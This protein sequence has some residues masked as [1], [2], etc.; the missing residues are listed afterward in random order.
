MIVV[1]DFFFVNN[2]MV[3]EVPKGHNPSMLR[4]SV[5]V[6]EILDMGVS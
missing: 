6:L 2:K 5:D 4:E 1:V 3:G